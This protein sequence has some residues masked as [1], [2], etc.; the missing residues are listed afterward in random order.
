MHQ[1]WT[2]TAIYFVIYK[3]AESIKCVGGVEMLSL[4]PFP[5][6]PGSVL[7]PSAI[8][9]CKRTNHMFAL[10]KKTGEKRVRLHTSH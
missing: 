2:R 10:L 4:K 7:N 5:L 8:L 6:N 9:S 1:P 3:L